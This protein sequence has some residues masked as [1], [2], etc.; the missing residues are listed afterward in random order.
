MNLRILYRSCA[1]ES[2]KPRPD[3]YSK[4]LALA[5]LL[6]AVEFLP[7]EPT[8]TFLNDGQPPFDRL[9]VMHAHGQV[10]G[11]DGGSP[12]RAYRSAIAWASAQPWPKGD[13]VW[14]AEDDYLYTEDSLLQLLSAAEKIPEADYLAMWDSYA[15]HPPKVGTVAPSWVRQSST[16]STFGVRVESLHRDA[17]LLRFMPYTGGAWDHT[18]GMVVQGMRPFPRSD[19][20][21]LMKNVIGGQRSGPDRRVMAAARM[22]THAAA[23]LTANFRNSRI[24]RD[25]EMYGSNPSLIFHMEET[26]TAHEW[27][28]V[29]TQTRRWAENT[30]GI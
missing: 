1:A 26:P 15:P 21:A 22:A 27:E 14:F 17:R 29:V 9:D 6:R 28:P 8:V 2:A 12:R 19:T 7:A 30:E 24:L 11:I 16:T 3:Y 20:W 5:S 4:D 18:T 13:L 25:S 10:V 23:N